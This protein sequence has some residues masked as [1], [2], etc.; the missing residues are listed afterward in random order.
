MPITYECGCMDIDASVWQ[1]CKFHQDLL[2]KIMLIDRDALEDAH[3]SINDNLTDF[4]ENI[5]K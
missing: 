2:V 4:M 1:L 5:E 3:K